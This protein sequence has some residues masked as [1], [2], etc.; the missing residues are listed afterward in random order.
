VYLFGPKSGFVGE[1]T[2]AHYKMT[3]I[4]FVLCIRKF[5]FVA[6]INVPGGTSICATNRNLR[7]H[8]EN[9]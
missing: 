8:I 6:Q 3:R 7:I 9:F 1:Y 4:L 5:L 2:N